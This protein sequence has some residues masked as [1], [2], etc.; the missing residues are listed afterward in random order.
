MKGTLR[1]SIIIPVLNEEKNLTELIPHLQKFGGD[2]IEDIQVVDGG[3]LDRSVVISESFGV[4]VL[5]SPEANR[6][7]QMNLGA[8][9]AKGNVLYFVHAD[10]RPPWD[11]AGQ[12]QIAWLKG[13]K[14]GCYRYQ[15]DSK[16]ILLKFNSY[17]TRFNGPFAGVGD[18]TLFITRGFFDRLG[19]FDPEFEMME[20]F[21]L[22][23]RIKKYSNFLILPE[24]VTVSA[25]KYSTNS[26]M[27]VQLLNA[28]AFILF[29]TN[30]D[31]KKI[32]SVY[33]NRLQKY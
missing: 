4:N 10:T 9:E 1:L 11:F 22:V 13:Y 21:E 30:S 7:A 23:K 33:Q 3:S 6:A 25:R 2:F 26:W 31:P 28:W 12:I 27:K 17:F 5:H 15:F 19:G 29:M 8:K 14:A 32:K 24:I 20:D 18:Q 16:S